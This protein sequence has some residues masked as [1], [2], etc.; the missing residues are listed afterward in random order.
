MAPASDLKSVAFVAGLFF[1]LP[2]YGDAP[3]RIAHGHNVVS[4]HDPKMEI[5]LPADAKYVGSDRWVLKVYADDIELHAFV[6]TGADKRIR[7]L[8]WVQFEAYLPSHP[9][10]K[11]SYDS[12]RHAIIGNLDFFVDTW[13]ESPDSA[14]EPDSDSAHLKTL[15]RSKGY[16][17]PS[18]MMSVRFVHVMD[19]ARKEL[20]FIYS[21]DLASTGL[22]AVDFKKGGKAYDR[23]P[24]LEKGLIA[25]GQQSL[26]LH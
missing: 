1:L 2:S 26:S 3:E 9:E 5:D 15:L 11:H 12:P 21:E 22:T 17:L 18:S 24:E 6:D 23:W 16:T 14:D 19:G 10:M 4:T 25:R 7:R 13:V 20:M 8:Y